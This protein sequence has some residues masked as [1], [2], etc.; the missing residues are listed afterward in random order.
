MENQKINPISSP[1]QIDTPAVTKAPVSQKPAANLPI[2]IWLSLGL[3]VLLFGATGF[4]TYK[5]Y[6]LRQRPNDQP[7]ILP[8]PT[9]AV[10]PSLSP[11][12]I[13]ESPEEQ[14]EIVIPDDWK[15]HEKSFAGTYF[16]FRYPKTNDVW[17]LDERSGEIYIIN[18]VGEGGPNWP[19]DVVIDN[20]LHIWGQFE[21][22]LS[23]S[24]RVWFINNLPKL[25]GEQDFSFLGFEEVSFSNGKTYLRVYN[26]PK[27][28]EFKNDTFFQGDFYFGVQ[29]GKVVYFS[30]KKSLSKEDIERILYS[31]EIR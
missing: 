25:Y 9:E 17:Y 12:G 1:E 5:Y 20:M 21:P 31:L 24:R 30:D 8:T 2:T 19:A 23:G 13:P 26:W 18:E 14:S 28:S 6:E 4:F 29:N 15:K 7:V 10:K 16:S 22:Y 11:T 3:V 27:T